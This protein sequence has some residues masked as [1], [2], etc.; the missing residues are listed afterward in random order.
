MAVVG[1]DLP[2]LAEHPH[3]SL[4]DM[5][6]GVLTR[7][8][9]G[10]DDERNP[11]WA[12]DSQSVVFQSRRGATYGIYRRSAGGGATGDELLFSAPE[13]CRPRIFQRR[14]AAADDE[15]IA[16]DQRVWVLR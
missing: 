13:P 6:R 11:V 2:V 3:L 16:A 12:P 5:D 10:R 1:E 4:M 7:F 9:T 14:H 8:T 15:G